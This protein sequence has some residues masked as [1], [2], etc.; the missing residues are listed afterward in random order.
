MLLTPENQAAVRD[1]FSRTPPPNP[2]KLSN[3]LS[4]QHESSKAREKTSITPVLNKNPR[5]DTANQ[6]FEVHS[7][8]DNCLIPKLKRRIM[9]RIK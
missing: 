4:T 3:S 5:K 2:N 9:D 1:K 6:V 8:G 7:G